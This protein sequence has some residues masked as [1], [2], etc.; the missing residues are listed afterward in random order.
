MSEGYRLFCICLH[1]KITVQMFE[2]FSSLTQS[3]IHGMHCFEAL[4]I[5]MKSAYHDEICL[6]LY[7]LTHT[8]CYIHRP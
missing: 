2:A 1:M 8:H 7:Q 6:R 4:L 5:M 3:L